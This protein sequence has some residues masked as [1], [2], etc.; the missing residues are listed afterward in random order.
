MLENRA[1]AAW[2]EKGTQKQ[3]QLCLSATRKLYTA[4]FFRHISMWRTVG[5]SARPV[6]FAWRLSS[7]NELPCLCGRKY[8]FEEE[9]LPF[10]EVEDLSLHQY[11]LPFGEVE[12]LSLHRYTL[13]F[14]E[15]E[16]M[17]LHRYT[18]PFGEVEDLS[19]Q[20]CTLPLTCMGIYN[21]RD[22]LYVFALFTTSVL[23]LH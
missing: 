5:D 19:L 12:D 14:G 11:T 2:G 3:R 1:K 10:G 22:T 8:T 20:W 17:S 21:F 9:E 15:A 6:L 23:L 18:L 16:N 13:P 4:Y 7:A